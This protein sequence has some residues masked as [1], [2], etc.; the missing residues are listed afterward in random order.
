MRPLEK[1]SEYLSTLNDI[2]QPKEKF[3]LTV[4]TALNYC[5][6]RCR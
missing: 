4:Y 6:Q 2:V 3:T 1:F 5:V